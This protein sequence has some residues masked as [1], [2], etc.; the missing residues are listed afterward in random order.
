MFAFGR[1]LKVYKHI[2]LLYLKCFIEQLLSYNF[3]QLLFIIGMFFYLL[4]V[5]TP[6]QDVLLNLYNFKQV[7][8]L[9]WGHFLCGVFSGCHEGDR[10]TNTRY[11]INMQRPGFVLLLFLELD[12]LAQLH[13]VHM[14]EL[15]LVNGAVWSDL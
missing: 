1:Y 9:S 13:A 6:R 4:E 2:A 3:Y 8:K 10:L 7:Y 14:F 12:S 15:L 11:V 5:A